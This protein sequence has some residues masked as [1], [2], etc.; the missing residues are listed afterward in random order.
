VKNNLWLLSAW[1]NWIYFQG[2]WFLINN[3][4]SF[5]QFQI[6]IALG[7]K[8][9]KKKCRMQNLHR[10]LLFQASVLWILING[11]NSII[12]SLCEMLKPAKGTHILG[13]MGTGSHG[14]ISQYFF[15]FLVATQK[16]NLQMILPF[17][18]GRKSQTAI[19][20]NVIWEAIYTAI[21]PFS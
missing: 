18:M 7:Q 2:V 20:R 6:E 17:I 11:N 5:T 15:F 21:C 10:P 12:S 3:V 19:S 9:K 16:G 13:L 4:N 8:K 14:T 1:D